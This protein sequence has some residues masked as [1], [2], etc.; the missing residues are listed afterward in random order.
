MNLFHDF[1]SL[2]FP[3]NCLA[4]HSSLKG[5]EKH[6]CQ[7]CFSQIPLTN[8]HKEEMSLMEKMFWGRVHLENITA[9]AFFEKK[10][11]VQHLLHELKY[12]GKKDLGFF[13]GQMLGQELL[14]N[15]KYEEI[16]ILVPV[17]LHVSK[18]RMRGYNQSEEIAKGIS[19]ILQKPLAKDALAC[20]R[21]TESQTRKTRFKRW[22][23]V[24]E[25]YQLSQSKKIENKH[26]LLVDDVITTGATIESCATQLLSC[27]G[28]KVSVASIAFAG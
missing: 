18:F 14:I 26:I 25:K 2:F 16:D 8:F 5:N 23:N 3:N 27:Q 21:T 9:Y 22:Q 12:K 10:G 24:E 17:P 11:I 20:M 15:K 1:F 7:A 13:L 28:T 6:I 19:D 4:C